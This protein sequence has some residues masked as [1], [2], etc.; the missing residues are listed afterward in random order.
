MGEVGLILLSSDFIEK[1]QVERSREMN[2]VHGY[3][4]WV[5]REQNWEHVLEV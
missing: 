4:G 1:F 2:R 5:E 3:G